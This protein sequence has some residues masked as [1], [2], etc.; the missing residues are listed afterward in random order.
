MF[1]IASISKLYDAV[2]IAKLAHAQRLSLD[3][4]IAEY[5]PEYA[6]RIEH[7]DQITLRMLVQH[8][9][10]IPNYTNH[11]GF[12]ENPLTVLKKPWI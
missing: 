7:A 8:R 3:Q 6:D 11:P 12:W 1:K 10:G 4:S 2:A 5:F 9:S